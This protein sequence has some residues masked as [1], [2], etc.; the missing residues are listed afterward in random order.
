M[1]EFRPL[2]LGGVYDA[3]LKVVFNKTAM[4]LGGIYILVS[5]PSLYVLFRGIMRMFFDFFAG[6][7]GQATANFTDNPLY[8]EFNPPPLLVIGL[9]LFYVCVSSLFNLMSCDLFSHRFF[10]TPYR[11]SQS[12]RAQLKKVPGHLLWLVFQGIYYGFVIVVYMFLS[13]IFSTLSIALG[14]LGQTALMVVILILFVVVFIALATAAEVFIFG[15]IPAYATDRGKL[16]RSIQASLVLSVKGFFRLWGATGLFRI[17]L[18]AGTIAFNLGLS[19]L[20]QAVMNALKA[21]AGQMETL[22]AINTIL[23]VMLIIIPGQITGNA[24]Q[25]MLYVNQRLR[26]EGLGAELLVR[27]F[28]SENPHPAGTEGA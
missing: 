17:I 22:L 27:R 16:F 24:F 4:L 19:Q 10:E 1:R 26:Y 18:A 11:L 5:L 9:L 14:T 28:I 21:S 23:Y 25:T 3:L 6:I 15:V 2:G 7:L 13:L 8:G 20:V 12:L